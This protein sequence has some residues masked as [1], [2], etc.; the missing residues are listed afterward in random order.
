MD[1]VGVCNLGLA[2]IGNRS[3]I[4]SFSDG[5]TQARTAALFY[6]PK[7]QMLARSAPWDSFRAQ[8][9]MT[10]LKAAIVNG[11][12]SS[13]PPPQP[14]QV[15]YAW[16]SDCLKARFIRPTLNA[17]STTIPLTTASQ[18][19]LPYAAA[20]NS[21]PFV[22]A[23]DYDTTGNPIKVILTNLYNA[24]LVYTRDLTQ[25][26]DLWDSLFLAAATALLGAY[27]INALARN[28][29]QMDEQVAIAQGAISQARAASANETINN[30][31]HIPDFLA[32]RTQSAVPW[33]WNTTG[34]NGV[35]NAGL[36][37][38]DQCEFPGGMF[39]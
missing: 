27:F 23:T 12:V 8:I 9:A 5:T 29:A 37:G 4:S 16:P 21:I 7:L 38:Y 3:P 35:Y 34:P 26:P 31:D 17:A 24:Q 22:P 13:N 39:F 30:I 10:Q 19:Y 36:G 1:P 11:V 15:E 25:V 33:A 6:T 18:T 20:P 14:F 2:E 28:K 32:V